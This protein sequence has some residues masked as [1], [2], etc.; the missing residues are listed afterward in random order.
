VKQKGVFDAIGGDALHPVDKRAN[1]I[2]NEMGD[3][4]ALVWVHT[5]RY[6]E[7][8][9]FAFA[10][11]QKIAD[12]IGVPVETV[13]LS[14]KYETGRFDYVQLVDGGIVEHPHSIAFE[15]MDQ[16][17]FQKFWDDVLEVLKDRWMPKLAED[18]FVEI[19]DMIAGERP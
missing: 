3:K 8:H 11:M 19:R 17:D 15:S 10:V 13:L 9:R 6:P 1:E 2:I 18:V 12:A 5:A 4:K 16:A 14:L 7:H